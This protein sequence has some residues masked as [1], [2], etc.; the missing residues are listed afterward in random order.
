MSLEEPG[1]KAGLGG[2]NAQETEGEAGPLEAGDQAGSLQTQPPW[3][4]ALGRQAK[5]R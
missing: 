1:F 5:A 2:G 3:E 4:A